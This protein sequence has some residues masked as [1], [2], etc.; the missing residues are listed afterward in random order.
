MGR[1]LNSAECAKFLG[2]SVRSLERMS[3]PRVQLSPR[4]VGYP[5]NLLDQW[6]ESRVQVRKT[7]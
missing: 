7:A 2:V 5:L 1:I 3:M 6:L 4:R